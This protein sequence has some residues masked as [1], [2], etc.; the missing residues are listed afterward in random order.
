E[1]LSVA[2]LSRASRV[3]L[4]TLKNW[5]APEPGPRGGAPSPEGQAESSD[6]A[7][8]D[9]EPGES[10]DDATPELPRREEAKEIAE[11]R[12]SPPRELPDSAAAMIRGTH[13]QLVV[14]LWLSWH[15]PFQAFCHMLRTEHGL[16]FGD[17]FIGDFL[18]ALG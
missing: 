6:S 1:N 2:D 17:T 16:T 8:G 14:T 5:L 7:E 18:Q 10:P 11:V 13:L 9:G 3:P 15:G 12:D 4:G